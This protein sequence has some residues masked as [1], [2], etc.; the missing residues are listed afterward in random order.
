MMQKSGYTWDPAGSCAKIRLGDGAILQNL[1]PSHSHVKLRSGAVE[2][3][4]TYCQ[5]MINNPELLREITMIKAYEYNQWSR[6]RTL[7]PK[8]YEN[9]KSLPVEKIESKSTQ[10]SWNTVRPMNA[11]LIHLGAKNRIFS[12]E[13]LAAKFSQPKFL[14][15]MGFIDSETDYNP[16]KYRAED[17]SHTSSTPS[18]CS[19]GTATTSSGMTA[20]SETVARARTPEVV[21]VKAMASEEQDDSDELSSDDEEYHNDMKDDTLLSVP[22]ERVPSSKRSNRQ[23]LTI[24]KDDLVI[25]SRKVTGKASTLIPD[26]QEYFKKDVDK[27][28]MPLSTVKNMN[29]VFN[30]N[31]GVDYQSSSRNGSFQSRPIRKDSLKLDVPAKIHRV[32]KSF[33]PFSQPVCLCPKLSKETLNSFYS[34]TMQKYLSNKVNGFLKCQLHSNMRHIRTREKVVLKSL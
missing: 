27:P 9:C 14:K 11:S 18:E 8:D 12:Y 21:E 4:D 13:D 33:V 24:Y 15:R 16:H 19:V 6:T 3:I 17:S 30:Q 10:P 32:D 29:E 34:P 1:Y 28:P 31:Q 25:G 7:N 23:R 26:E 22:P 2:R 20:K 5:R